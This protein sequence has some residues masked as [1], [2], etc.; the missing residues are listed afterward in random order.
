MTSTA[1]F[2][3]ASRLLVALKISQLNPLFPSAAKY[4]AP[5]PGFPSRRVCWRTVLPLLVCAFLFGTV[6]AGAQRQEPR[7]P[8]PKI[9]KILG[10]PHEQAFSGVVQ[11]LDMKHKVLNVSN[12]QGG[13]AEIFPIKKKTR[14]QTA[15]GDKLKIGSLTPGLNVLIYYERKTDRRDVKRIVV[16]ASEVKG[17]TKPKNSDSHS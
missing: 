11:S 12:V 1:K 6:M 17:S 2:P 14:V 5:A 3:E 7:M 13:N 8:L 15:D 16:L 10:G 9:G 4:P